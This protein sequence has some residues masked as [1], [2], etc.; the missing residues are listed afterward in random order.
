MV[1]CDQCGAMCDVNKIFPYKGKFLCSIECYGK[2]KCN[3]PRPQKY[4][5]GKATGLLGVIGA[6]IK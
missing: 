4:I 6:S 2:F 5:M 3:Q 1:R